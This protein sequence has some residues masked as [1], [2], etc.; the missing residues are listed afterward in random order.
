MQEIR[1]EHLFVHPPQVVF[2]LIGDHE[3]FFPAPRYRC[4]LLT[5]GTP[6][7]NGDGAVREI[8]SG[9][10]RFVETISAL[11]PGVGFDYRVQTLHA[12]GLPV[13]FRH[14]RGWLEFIAEGDGCRVIWRSQFRM[15][16][17]LLGGLL[18]KQFARSAG[19]AFAWLLG[20]AARRLD[21]GER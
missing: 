1:A 3:R 21:A 9:A 20:Q 15:A 5:L 14:Q 11:T 8:R 12:G 18:E 13:P 10:L 7:R 16:V 2:A 19:A 6:Q 17:P 4:R